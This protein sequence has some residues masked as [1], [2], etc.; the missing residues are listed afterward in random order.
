LDPEVAN[1]VS[2]IT[3]VA[4]GLLWDREGGARGSP[5]LPS[6]PKI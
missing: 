1:L 5:P 2:H 6:V 3:Q 4:A